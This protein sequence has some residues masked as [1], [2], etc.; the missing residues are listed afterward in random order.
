[1]H[2]LDVLRWAIGKREHPQQILCTGGLYERGAPSDQETPNAQY[3]TFQYADGTTLRCDVQGWYTG[4]R[5]GGSYI[6]GTEGW[7]ELDG[8]EG[9]KIYLGRKNEPGPDLRKGLG[10]RGTGQETGPDPHFQNFID[11]VR[12][13]KWQSLAADVEEGFMSTALCHLGNISYRLKRALVFDGRRERFAS[14]AE[15]N[16]LLSRDYR[17]PFVV[18]EKV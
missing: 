4:T 14:D 8:R 12:S 18:P 11:C 7:M 16:R 3:A 5:E 15:A 9:P 17:T 6:Y 10:A 2:V 13:R 1:V